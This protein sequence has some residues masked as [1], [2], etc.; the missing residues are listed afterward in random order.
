VGWRSNRSIN[1]SDH[2]GNLECGRVFGGQHSPFR[3]LCPVFLNVSRPVCGFQWLLQVLGST[4]RHDGAGGRVHGR[5]TCWNVEHRHPSCTVK[6]Q[7][8]RRAGQKTGQSQ[9]G[10]EDAAA[11]GAVCVLHGLGGWAGGRC[12]VRGL[13]PTTALSVGLPCHRSASPSSAAVAVWILDGQLACTTVITVA[14]GGGGGGGGG[15]P[16]AC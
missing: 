7:A 14:W 9:E 8:C 4:G 11:P 3:A 12:S 13:P 6:R 1:P 15:V 10:S 5:R 2:L 16:C